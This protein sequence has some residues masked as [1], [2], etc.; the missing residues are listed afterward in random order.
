MSSSS[1][2]LSEFARN[3]Y[4]T[5]S[6]SDFKLF[7][8]DFERCAKSGFFHE[9][10]GLPTGYQHVFNEQPPNPKMQ[11]NNVL[12]FLHKFDD[13]HSML[14]ESFNNVDNKH[15]EDDD[16]LKYLNAFVFFSD[17]SYIFNTLFGTT[18]IRNVFEKDFM[19]PVAEFLF[20]GILP[21]MFNL[22]FKFV[23]EIFNNKNKTDQ[24]I[25]AQKEFVY[26]NAF[27]QIIS[28]SQH[29]C[30]ILPRTSV[31][32]LG[33]F[34]TPLIRDTLIDIID[35][36]LKIAGSTTTSHS[37]LR[38]CFNQYIGSLCRMVMRITF[39]DAGEKLLCVDSFVNDTMMPL[40]EGC[41]DT[42]DLHYV[43]GVIR[44]ICYGAEGQQFLT[45]AA[46]VHSLVTA[47]DH[48]KTSHWIDNVTGLIGNVCTQNPAAQKM[49]FKHPRFGAAWA[50]LPLNLCD[51]REAVVAYAAFC[52]V[53]N[54]AENEKEASAFDEECHSPIPFSP[55][56]PFAVFAERVTIINTIL[57]LL[58]EGS[59]CVM[60]MGN[61]HFLDAVENFK[62]KHIPSVNYTK[63]VSMLK[64]EIG[65]NKLNKLKNE[66]K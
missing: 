1:A 6:I 58:E 16:D 15:L 64:E 55:F 53:R 28:A 63:V 46:A 12:A 14:I 51:A 61:Q 3:L 34:C 4:A 25:S 13:F 24:E 48:S 27:S 21:S 10:L 35:R 36:S 40:L 65:R 18:E 26:S 20:S 66:K 62:D 60:L 31:P 42:G 50:K 41:S 49:F 38:D 52:V 9:Y 8:D 23:D 5:K 39:T 19:E 32:K 33:V 2:S 7:A 17:M 30:K 56:D 54:G 45:N 29:L 22:F 59:R 11:E 44:N 47:L 57:E 43:S 37:D